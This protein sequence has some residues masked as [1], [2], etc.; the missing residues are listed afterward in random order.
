MSM[1]R[2]F[3]CSALA[4]ALGGLALPAAAQSKKE[5]AQKIV[6]IQQPAVEALARSIAEQPAAQ[7]MQEAGQLL[8]T[9]VPEAK[10]QAAAQA[11]E[12]DVK[13]YAEEASALVRERAV[14]LSPGTL[15]TALEEK[16]SEDELKQII[17]WLES[18]AYKKYQQ[19]L[20]EVQKNLSQKLV[21]DTRPSVEPKIRTLQANIRKHLG[22]P[23]QPPAP[24]SAP[25]KPK[26]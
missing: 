17:A 22:L 8:R 18:P 14:K 2:V 1:S 20:P 19:V 10:R 13:K 5:L 7:L 24:A 16:F 3:A 6:Q 9:Q 4:L 12:A 21:E 11:I 26:K 15:G 23:E 25:A